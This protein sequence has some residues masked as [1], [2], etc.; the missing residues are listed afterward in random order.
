[1][2]SNSGRMWIGTY[3]NP[4]FLDMCNNWLQGV[5]NTLKASYTCGQLEKGA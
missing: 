3:N 4:P 5:H 1:M 2:N